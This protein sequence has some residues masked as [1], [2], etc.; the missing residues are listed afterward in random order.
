MVEGDIADSLCHHSLLHAV[1]W[2]YEQ[3]NFG[4]EDKVG[5]ALDEENFK[6]SN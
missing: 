1:E 3:I 2:G 6:D 5:C 4:I